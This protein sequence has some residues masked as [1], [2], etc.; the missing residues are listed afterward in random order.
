MKSNISSMPRTA[1]LNFD[2]YPRYSFLGHRSGFGATI[3]KVLALIGIGGL[4]FILGLQVFTNQ[5]TL[6]LLASQEQEWHEKTIAVKAKQQ[7]QKQLPVSE[8]TSA[9]IR[10][11]NNVIRQLNVPWK[12]MFEDL[13]SMTPMDVALISIE[14]DGAR[15]TVKLVAEAKSLTPLLNYSS[16]LQQ[17]G[18]FGRITY[19]KHETNEQDTNK[20]VRLSFELELRSALLTANTTTETDVQR[21]KVGQP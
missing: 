12:N 11:Y 19:T 21:L 17:N 6:E 10:G 1:A 8:L 2:S 3:C 9:Q 14:P 5:Q 13:E 15:S 4:L 20:P 18:I 16:K 7:K